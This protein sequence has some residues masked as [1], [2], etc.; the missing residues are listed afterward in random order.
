MDDSG[1][2]SQLPAGISLY[3]RFSNIGP[4][5]GGAFTAHTKRFP[6]VPFNVQDK[7]KS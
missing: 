6:I 5:L 7:T 2:Y 3:Q 4:I 1:I